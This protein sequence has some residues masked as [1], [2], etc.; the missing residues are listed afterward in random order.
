M[1]LYFRT[2]L[3]APIAATGGNEI[4]HLDDLLADARYAQPPR[5]MR[6]GARL[7]G[8]GP[9]WLDRAAVRS[10][11]PTRIEIEPGAIWQLPSRTHQLRLRAQLLDHQVIDLVSGVV[12]RMNDVVLARTPAGLA[13][14]GVDVGLTGLMRALAPRRSRR[15]LGRVHPRSAW[16]RELTWADIDPVESAID[17]Y[18]LVDAHAGIQYLSSKAIARVL[19]SLRPSDRL[20]MLNTLDGES[21]AAVLEAS[22]PRFRRRLIAQLRH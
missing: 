22:D 6:I 5:V 8:R 16:Q 21:V 19:R 13:V 18:Q 12:T 1:T 9:R 11:D 3:G 20:A 15:L 10:F 2:L 17:H 14:T 7:D 4:G